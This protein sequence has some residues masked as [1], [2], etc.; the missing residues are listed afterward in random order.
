[1]GRKARKPELCVR[2][3]FT[4][5]HPIQEL[6]AQAY[7][8]Y[9]QEKQKAKSSDHTFDLAESTDYN[10]TT[11]KNKEDKNDESAA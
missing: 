1:M 9:F 10:D 7:R 5:E 8:V 2:R 3:E 4:N 6:F 11:D